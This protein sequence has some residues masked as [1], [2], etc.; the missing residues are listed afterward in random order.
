VS[1]Y[2][3][4]LIARAAGPAAPHPHAPAK[5]T[6]GMEDPFEATAPLETPLSAPVSAPPAPVLPQPATVATPSAPPALEQRGASSTPVARPGIEPP[7]KAPPPLRAAD[8]AVPSTKE[9]ADVDAAEQ[10]IPRPPR[11]VETTRIEREVVIRPDERPTVSAGPAPATREEQPASAPQPIRIEKETTREREVRV[12]REAATREELTAPRP[13]LKPSIEPRAR[14]DRPPAPITPESH[15][16][17]RLVI[18]RMNVEVVPAAPPVPVRQPPVRV[19]SRP[20]GP[21]RDAP[22]PAH[23]SVGLGQM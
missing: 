9:A 17:P 8:A 4:R 10:P 16:A 5:Q 3:A 18:G 2:F 14:E 23:L 7:R 12:I 20:A 11:T 22:A 15:A 21:R 6:A 1:R 13:A 19:A